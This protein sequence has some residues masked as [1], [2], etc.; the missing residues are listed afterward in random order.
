MYLVCEGD[1]CT[2]PA[3]QLSRAEIA[4][5]Q[6]ERCAAGHMPMISMPEKVV[7]VIVKAAQA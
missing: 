3:L 5:S 2:R 7:E 4:G 1:K 6:V